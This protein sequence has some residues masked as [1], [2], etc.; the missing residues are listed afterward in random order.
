[1]DEAGYTNVNAATGGSVAGVGTPITF[2]KTSGAYRLRV[3]RLTGTVHVVSGGIYL[4]TSAGSIYCPFTHTGRPLTEFLDVPDSIK[5]PIFTDLALHCLF[6]NYRD[7]ATSITADLPRLKT[8]VDTYCASTDTDGVSTKCDVICVAATP[9]EASL[10]Y[11]ATTLQNVAMRSACIINNWAYFDANTPFISHAIGVARGI[12]AVADVHPT[13]AGYAYAVSCCWEWLAWFNTIG[14]SNGHIPKATIATLSSTT[15][16]IS[17]VLSGGNNSLIAGWLFGT[18]GSLAQPDLRWRLI[19]P[20]AATFGIRD[21]AAA[22]TPLI[23]D[24]DTP[25]MYPSSSVYELGKSGSPY[26]GLNLLKTM[27]AAGTTGD[28][29]IN[30]CHG[31]VNFAALS[32]TPIV[33]TNSKAATTSNIIPVVYGTDATLTSVRI[34]K[35]AGSFTITPNAAATNETAVGFIVIN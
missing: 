29:T 28:R 14:I 35:A 31:T 25:S 12:S 30:S 19:K 3:V 6:V 23:M 13:T 22:Q 34:T 8:F 16:T 33:V 4:S 15:A 9:I 1:V 21:T 18:D 32:G 2:T 7:D 27:T 20:S 11:A 24:S 10:D 17:G 26:G 5:G